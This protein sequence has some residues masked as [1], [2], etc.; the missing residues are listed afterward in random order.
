MLNIKIINNMNIKMIYLKYDIK[1]FLKN[2]KYYC[3]LRL[4]EAKNKNTLYFVFEPTSGHPGL[5]DR[6]KAIIRLYNAAKKNEMG[7]KVFFETPFKLDD[8]FRFRK[9]N[10]LKL[11]ELEYSISDTRIINECNWHE[12]PKLNNSK[13][14]HC[15]NYAGN[16]MPWE[17]PD[18]GYKWHEL[19]QELFEPSDKLIKVYESLNLPKTDYITIQLRFVNALDNFEA[20]SCCDNALNSESEKQI[21]IEKCKRGIQN[22]IDKNPN[23]PVYVFSDSK[24][25]L[26]LLSD[27]DVRVLSY[28][29][30]GHSGFVRDDTSQMRTFVDL[31]VMSRS[32]AIYRIKAKE[33]YNLSCFALLASRMNNVKFIDVD[34]G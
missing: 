14:Y 25:F 8:Y 31:L 34:L 1:Y 15:Y 11:D 22:I 12:I 23:T 6:M 21:L 17:F 18:T 10:T 3:K 13:Q 5:A 16:D 4:C 9:N 30:V 27:M 33:L 19:F 2:I 7:F 28:G 32:K 26:D 29:N 24:R 20:V